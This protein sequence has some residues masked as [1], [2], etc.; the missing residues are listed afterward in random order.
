M[1]C[2]SK[3]VFARWRLR[4]KME[5]GHAQLARWDRRLDNRKLEPLSNMLFEQ[6]KPLEASFA[7]DPAREDLDWLCDQAIGLVAQSEVGLPL[8]ERI[9]VNAMYLSRCAAQARTECGRGEIAQSA[10]QCAKPMNLHDGCFAAERIW[11]G[12]FDALRRR[13]VQ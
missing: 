4:C 6:V 11:S 10:G 2:D 3:S 12:L 1:A 7:P 13:V 8:S 9:A 5:A